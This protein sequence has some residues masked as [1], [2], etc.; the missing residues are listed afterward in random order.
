[1][2]KFR[3]SSGGSARAAAPAPLLNALN[4]VIAMR[5]LSADRG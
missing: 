3:A 4:V 2:K 5:G 1:M